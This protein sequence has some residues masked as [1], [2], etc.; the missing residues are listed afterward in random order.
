[1]SDL[2]VIT[3]PEPDASDYAAEL[4]ANGFDVFVEPMLALEGL[5]FARPDLSQYDGIL[6][7]SVNALRFYKDGGGEL[8]D[9]AVYCVGKHTAGMAREIGFKDVISV[10]G[11]GVDL[12]AYILALPD[13][14]SQ[15]FLHICGQYVAFPLVERLV[16]DGITAD[17]LK[18]YESVQS[19]GFSEAFL[20]NLKEGKVNTVTFF[21]SVRLR[22]LFAMCVQVNLSLCLQE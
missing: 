15:N 20:E 16:E 17:S 21:Q 2:I 5:V 14:Q 3:R 13:V 18:V 19:S 22:H 11:T 1:M 7:T 6:A 10:H 4:R 12:L 8:A 9:I